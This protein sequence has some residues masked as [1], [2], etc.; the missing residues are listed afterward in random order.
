MKKKRNTTDY[1]YGGDYS[2][3]LFSIA[4]E[5][6]PTVQYSQDCFNAEHGWKRW[7][8]RQN[9]PLRRREGLA[10]RRKT[11]R[12]IPSRPFLV[13]ALTLEGSGGILRRGSHTQLLCSTARP[14]FPSSLPGLLQYILTILL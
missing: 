14:P 7:K 8:N 5:R 12:G 2:I 11:R 3:M 13:L 6:A 10:R 9:V 1:V 4:I